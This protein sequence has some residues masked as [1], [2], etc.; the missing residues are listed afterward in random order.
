MALTA[1][2]IFN[3]AMLLNNDLKASLAEKLVESIEID[4]NIEAAH[5]KE[6]KKRRDEIRSGKV[7]G[8]PGDEA[9]AR[10]RNLV[11]QR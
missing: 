9:L 4:S 8:I 11:L 3:A 6:V 1:D 7:R 2:Q 10:V 5:I